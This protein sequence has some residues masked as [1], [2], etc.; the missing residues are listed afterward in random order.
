MIKNVYCMTCGKQIVS[1]ELNIDG[2]SHVQIIEITAVCDKPCVRA[3]KTGFVYHEL[4]EKKEVYQGLCPF[5]GGS[6]KDGVCAAGAA[7][8]HGHAATTWN[9][10]AGE[11]TDG[12]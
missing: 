5:C 6:T 7:G 12:V 1:I 3:T 4:N 11:T 8:L 10:F 9:Y 2:N